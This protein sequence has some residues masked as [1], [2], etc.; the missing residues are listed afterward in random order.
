M[1][2]VFDIGGVVFEDMWEGIFFK[3]TQGLVYAFNL[4]TE[5]ASK[6]CVDCWDEFSIKSLSGTTCE[7]L[8][9]EYWERILQTLQIPLTIQQCIEFSKEYIIPITGIDELICSIDTADTEL[10]VCSNQTAFWFERQYVQSK[11]LQMIGRNNMILSFEQGAG[12]SY[13]DNFLFNKVI[14]MFDCNADDIIYVE[15]RDAHLTS[16]RKLGFNTISFDKGKLNYLSV[17]KKKLSSHGVKFLG[18]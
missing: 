17:L 12:K 5:K 9:Q 16:A 11:G 7:T 10:G 15:D 14:Q 1:P 3:K 2:I 4:D 8:E 6:V 18:E 13:R